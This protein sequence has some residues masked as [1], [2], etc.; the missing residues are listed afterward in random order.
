MTSYYCVTNCCN[1]FLLLSAQDHTAPGGLLP[2]LRGLAGHGAEPAGHDYDLRAAAVTSDDQH[3]PGAR[4]L[5]QPGQG[6]LLCALRP[7]PAA[8]RT[9]R[10][11]GAA[12]GL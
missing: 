2:V 4:R 8:Q 1:T 6:S 11:G 5:P 9:G 10:D 7:Q 12:R 3:V